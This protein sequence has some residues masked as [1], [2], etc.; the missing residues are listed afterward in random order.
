MNLVAV[1]PETVRVVDV[2]GA[3]ALLCVSEWV[4]RR[5]IDDGLLATFKLP[6]AKNAGERNRRVLILV[7]EIDAFIARQQVAR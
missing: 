4:L 2:K 7:S 3:A 6:S 1:A 5:Y